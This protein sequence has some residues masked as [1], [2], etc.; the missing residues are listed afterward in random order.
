MSKIISLLACIC[1]VLVF[2]GFRSLVDGPGLS[3]VGGIICPQA[4]QTCCDRDILILVDC[5][6][7]TDS[8]TKCRFLWAI[9]QVLQ[10]LPRSML[11]LPQTADLS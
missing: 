5:I 11:L 2:V 7:C 4:S 10:K 9:A 6:N 3:F 1:I 8:V